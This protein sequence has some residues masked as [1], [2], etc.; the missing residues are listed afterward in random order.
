[1]NAPN[2]L[3]LV[4]GTAIWVIAFV[5]VTVAIFCGGKREDSRTPHPRNTIGHALDNHRPQSS[6][7]LPE[8]GWDTHDTNEGAR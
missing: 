3:W 6:D 8:Y 4:A 5:S 2:T 1:M 7:D